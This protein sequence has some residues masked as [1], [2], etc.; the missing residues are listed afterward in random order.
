MLDALHPE[1]FPES[2]NPLLQKGRD[3]LDGTVVVGETSTPVDDDA[4]G[5]FYGNE[6]FVPDIFHTIGNDSVI[7]DGNGLLF[8]E[9]DNGLPAGIGINGP[10]RGDGNDSPRDLE[11]SGVVMT[12][13]R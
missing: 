4:V 10:G 2:F 7:P 9:S 12:H 8:K 5:F 3:R 6:K 1:E 11:W 13:D